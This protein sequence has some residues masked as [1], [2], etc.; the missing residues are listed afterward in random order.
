MRPRKQTSGLRCVICGCSVNVER[1]HVGGQNHVAWFR[2]PFCKKHHDQFHDFLRNA[3]INLEYTS[4]PR[5]R[6]LR[7]L[8][9]CLVAQWMITKTLQELDCHTEQKTG[10]EDSPKPGETHV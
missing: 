6:L 1:N 4:D 7:A 2:M 8:Q 5:E 3:G 10:S 9:A